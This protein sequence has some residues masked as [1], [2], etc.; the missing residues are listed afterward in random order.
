MLFLLVKMPKKNK[1]L[2]GFILLGVIII[3]LFCFLIKNKC[4]EPPKCPECNCP[5]LEC[6]NISQPYVEKESYSYTLKY[7]VV[8]DVTEGIFLEGD[9]LNW[10]TQQ[11]TKL[12]N[13][14]DKGGNFKVMHYYRTLKKEG[15][16][17]IS[18]YINAGETKEL[19][20]TF[21]NSLGEDIEV[22]TKIIPPT[23]IRYKEVIKYK[24]IEM[25]SCS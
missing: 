17:E 6:V 5:T 15:T 25:C 8:K 21:D 13:F 11:T 20:T 1:T 18:D 3:V 16:K 10:G 9:S 7:G 22:T 23:E 14:D 2:C 19:V 24:L 4:P 12:K